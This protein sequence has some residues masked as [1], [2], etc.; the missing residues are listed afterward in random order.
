M[1]LTKHHGLGND[2]LVLLDPD[3]H[4]ALGERLARHL[5]D[6]HLGVGADGLVRLGGGDVFQLRNADGSE[7]ETSGNGLRCLGQAVAMERGVDE[8]DLVVQT[9]AGTRRIAVRPGPHV[10]TASVRVGMGRVV[11]SAEPPEPA[12]A[13]GALK[14]MAVDL[15]N[16]HTVRLF[17]ERGGLDAAA[18]QETAGT[19]NVEFVMAGPGPDELTMRVVERGVGETAA[20][21]TGACAAA[22]AAHG[23][24]LVGDRVTV[25]MP[26]GSLQVD[27]GETVSLTGP[28]RFVAT[29]QVPWP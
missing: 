22:W 4:W 16:P 7:A 14:A 23:W 18:D 15:G 26:G 6:R 10:H 29:V 17:A 24:G 2:F 27:L 1:R 25:H 11:E 9:S 28:A 13:D 21:G 12:G 20:C 19:R 3:D 5:C 8:L